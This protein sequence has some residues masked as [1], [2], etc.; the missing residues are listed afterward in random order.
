[1]DSLVI[2]P[3]GDVPI[4][5]NLDLKLGNIH[6]NTLDEIFNG[7]KSQELQKEYKNNCNQ[8]WINFHRKYDVVMFRTMEKI[9]PKWM[10][11]I[12]FGEYNWNENK[13][14]TY[15]EFMAEF[16]NEN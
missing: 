10:V 14:V 9:F 13:K 6:E 1:M 3:N 16:E 12:A 7:K 2:L 4:C 8:C 11:E 5:Q 15:K